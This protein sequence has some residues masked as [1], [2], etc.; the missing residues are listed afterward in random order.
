[1]N[2]YQAKDKL[3]KN[4]EYRAANPDGDEPEAARMTAKQ[5][6]HADKVAKEWQAE[7]NAKEIEREKMAK[8][9]EVREGN[10]LLKSLKLKIVSHHHL[11]TPPPPPP[12]ILPSLPP[13]APPVYQGQSRLCR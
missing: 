10:H 6:A 7:Q 11:T 2:Y 3:K 1:M 9:H 13:G 5:K 4:Q 8:E 12:H